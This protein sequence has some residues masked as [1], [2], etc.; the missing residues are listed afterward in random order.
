[1]E[2]DVNKLKDGSYTLHINQELIMQHRQLST[3][4]A[5]IE[6]YLKMRFL[7]EKDGGMLGNLRGAVFGQ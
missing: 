7:E 3:V 2:I 4:M 6:Q 1:M 5:K